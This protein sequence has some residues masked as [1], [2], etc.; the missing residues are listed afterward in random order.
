[1][2]YIDVETIKKSY[3]S[4]SNITF[5]NQSI[6]HIFFLLK[7]IDVSNLEY[8]SLDRIKDCYEQGFDFCSLYSP[9]EEIPEKCN[10]INPFMMKQWSTNPT[11]SFKKWTFS[12]VKSNIVGGATT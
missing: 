9:L 8:T 1:M 10:F 2:F 5:K 6:L 12:R 4:L 3:N 7:A 11:E